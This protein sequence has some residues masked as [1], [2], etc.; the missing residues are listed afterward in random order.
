MIFISFENAIGR[1]KV[2]S[3]HDLVSLVGRAGDTSQAHKSFPTVFLCLPSNIS[4][5]PESMTHCLIRLPLFGKYLLVLV[6][7]QC[8]FHEKG[9][10]G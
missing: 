1:W 7:T 5:G 8:I 4:P 3:C 6:E 9:L 10:K 2:F